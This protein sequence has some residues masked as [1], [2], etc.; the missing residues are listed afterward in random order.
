MNIKSYKPH[1][2][3]Q[4]IVG[5]LCIAP[6][7]LIKTAVFATP[8]SSPIKIYHAIYA[9]EF[10]TDASGQTLWIINNT[11]QKKPDPASALNKNVLVLINK[12]SSDISFKSE[13][14]KNFMVTRDAY[15][16]GIHEKPTTLSTP[17]YLLDPDW[18]ACRIQSKN[19]IILSSRS[20][21]K[22]PQNSI[23]NAFILKGC[24]T[25]PNR[26]SSWVVESDAIDEIIWIDNRPPLAKKSA[27]YERPPHYY[28]G[29]SP[30]IRMLDQKLQKH[31]QQEDEKTEKK[32]DQ[33]IAKE[34][35]EMNKQ[36]KR[37]DA[38]VTPIRPK[39]KDISIQDTR[40]QPFLSA[41]AQDAHFSK[42][43]PLL[44]I[45]SKHRYLVLFQDIQH[46]N[47]KLTEMAQGHLHV[48]QEQNESW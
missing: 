14:T 36:L 40:L 26:Y 38:N 16:Q 17:M 13:K 25:H 45:A 4:R 39:Q 1:R 46:T 41:A 9:M 8:S 43:R 48:V 18:E 47:L 2:I 10:T 34:F 30:H 44:F 19:E 7:A 37:I 15:F 24:A 27:T 12:T 21:K 32:F 23:W 6:L 28:D 3:A 33:F 20:N 22:E 29:M 42:Y 31:Y 11:P 5:L 35:L